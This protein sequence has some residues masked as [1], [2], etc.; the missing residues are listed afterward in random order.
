[1]NYDLFLV[2][3]GILSAFSLMLATRA[4][5]VKLD[6]PCIPNKIA[7]FADSYLITMITG[8]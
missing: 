5:Y 8:L 1:M 4:V 6:L 7:K 3:L 2:L